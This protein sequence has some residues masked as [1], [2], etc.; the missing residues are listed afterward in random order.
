MSTNHN[1]MLTPEVADNPL[2]TVVTPVY[3][4][5]H[6]LDETI[7]S[8]RR[9]T[10]DNLRYV[11]L[12]DNSSDESLEVARKH[13]EQDDRLEVF[14]VRNGSVSLTRQM[15]V[16]Q[17]GSPLVAF[18][19]NDDIWHPNFLERSV[20][21]LQRLG[22]RAVGT[23]CMLNL[24][25]QNSEPIEQPGDTSKGRHSLAMTGEVD[26]DN[27]LLGDTPARTAGAV[28]MRAAALEGHAFLQEAEPCEDYELWLRILDANPDK[29][30]YGLPDKLL[31]YR[32]RD[33]QQTSNV[34]KV[35]KTLDTMY[36]TYVPRMKDPE[37]RWQV[38]QYASHGAR[39]RGLL[40]YDAH[41]GR[42]AT[43]LAAMPSIEI[44]PY[45]KNA[46]RLHLR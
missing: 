3:N 18:L 40:D 21:E 37:A 38:Y 20:A 9:Q 45:I 36:Q 14:A 39:A 8:V 12:D 4:A 27:Y 23:Y 30:M 34:E 25:N 16:D 33:D 32:I 1:R 42:L 43:D 10:Y 22:E 7:S 31:S 11:I 15:G 19:D 24:I 17:A 44:Q 35:F 28:V 29:I 5:A 13:A 6:W 41:F 2:V 46:H 26:F